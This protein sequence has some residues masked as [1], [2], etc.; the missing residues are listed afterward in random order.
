MGKPQLVIE[1]DVKIGRMSEITA[2]SSVVLKKG[3][4]LADNVF[5]ADNTHHYSNI[6]IP[7]IKQ[8]LDK[9]NPVEIGSTHGLDGMYA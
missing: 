1:D 2:V 3:V 9:L 5:I 7:I 4:R 6:D 8:G